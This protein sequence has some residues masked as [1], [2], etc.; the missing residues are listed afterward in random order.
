MN[1]RSDE[2]EKNRKQYLHV[3]ILLLLRLIFKP[4]KVHNFTE[5]SER[6][7]A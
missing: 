3:I 7:S 5:N 6:L 2:A 1:E 4:P